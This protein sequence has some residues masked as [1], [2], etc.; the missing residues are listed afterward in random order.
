MLPPIIFNSGFNMRK[1]RFFANLGNIML[2][3]LAV[4]LVCFTLYAVVCILAVKNF[5][6]TATNYSW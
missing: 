3:G 5:R 1:K 4:T 6:M 2:F